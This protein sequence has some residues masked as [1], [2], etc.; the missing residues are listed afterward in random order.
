VSA[1]TVSWHDARHRCQ[2]EGGDLIAVTDSKVQEKLV[3][4]IAE[5]KA[6][7]EYFSDTRYFWLGAHAYDGQWKWV[8]HRQPFNEYTR[9]RG[10]KANAGCEVVDNVTVCDDAKALMMNYGEM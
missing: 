7:R 2:L 6:T 8:S 5:K 1:V 9:W 4:F 10:G 3:S